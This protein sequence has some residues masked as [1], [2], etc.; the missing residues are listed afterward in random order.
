MKLESDGLLIS[1]R[2]LNER[3]S[4]ARIFTSEF[5]VLCGVLKGAQVA[6]KNRPLVGQIGAAAW[7]A[8]LES[9]LGA[10]HWDATRNLSAPIMMNAKTLNFMNAAFD[11]ICA[12]LPEREEYPHLYNDTIELLTALP[13][14]PTAETYLSWEVAFLRELG[15]ALNLS[16]CGGCGAHNNLIYLSP[17]TGRAVCHTCGAPYAAKLYQL[18]LTLSTTFQFIDNICTSLGIDVPMSRRWL[19]SM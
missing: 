13:T 1:L 12:L 17:R 7:N 10:F 8:R 18:P 5:G 11:L 3:D 4:V 9:Q 6:K 16:A 15:Y 19:N 14:A 2:A